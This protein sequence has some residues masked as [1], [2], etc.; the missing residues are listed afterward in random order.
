MI[1]LQVPAALPLGILKWDRSRDVTE[2]VTLFSLSL[3]LEV[4][5]EKTI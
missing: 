3:S 1:T 2:S 4:Q 5:A